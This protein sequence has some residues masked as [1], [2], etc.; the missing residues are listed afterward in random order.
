MRGAAY[1]CRAH[2]R[3][4]LAVDTSDR[5]NRRRMRMAVVGDHVGRHDDSC[6]RLVDHVGDGSCA[7]VVVVRPAREAPG[8][9]RVR[10]RA[11]MRRI[12]QVPTVAST[13]PFTPVIDAVA[14]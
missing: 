3:A 7:D 12:A 13:S 10:T 14:V 1:V 8:V 5:N 11:R 6:I 9:S 2:G 4:G